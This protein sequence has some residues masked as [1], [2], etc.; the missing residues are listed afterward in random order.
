MP[1]KFGIP[2]CREHDSWKSMWNRC[3]NPNNPRHDRY[4][5]RGIKVCER[6]RDFFVF[7]EDMGKR[8]EDTTL[9]RIDNDG[10]YVPENCRWA[11]I[12]E[13]AENKQGTIRLTVNGVT[14]TLAN[15]ARKNK[16]KPGVIYQRIERG[17]TDHAVLVQPRSDKGPRNE[18]RYITIDG[19]TKC[20]QDWC[21]HYK[22][23]DSKV[24]K[25]FLRLEDWKAAFLAS[26][27]DLIEYRQTEI[28]IDGEIRSIAGWA[29]KNRVTMTVV[30]QRIFLD[31]ATLQQAVQA[32]S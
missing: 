19:E 10:D 24:R 7:L 28:E 2:S 8:P 11:T 18:H 27:Y 32:S 13:Q 26:Q 17:E 15:W 22:V 5:E 31:G 16:V 1:S 14:D 25:L 30:W 12:R 6:W 3:C 20:F 4:G 23:K 21:R 29:K 9:D